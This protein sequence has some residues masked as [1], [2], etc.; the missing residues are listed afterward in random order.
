MRSGYYD[1]ELNEESQPKSAFVEDQK[2]ASG[3]SRGVFL[4]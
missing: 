3:N 4:G 1:L 2:V